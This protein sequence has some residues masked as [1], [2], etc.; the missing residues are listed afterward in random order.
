MWRW[1]D[2]WPAAAF[3]VLDVGAAPAWGVAAGRPADGGAIIDDLVHAGMAGAF[4]CGVG[5]GS[6]GVVDES[7]GGEWDHGDAGDACGGQFPVSGFAVAQHG[8]GVGVLDQVWPLLVRAGD[9][10]AGPE[11]HAHLGRRCGALAAPVGHICERVE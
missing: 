10:V 8:V 1:S 5:A 4:V 7:G 2:W 6:C 9:L 11:Q 3:L